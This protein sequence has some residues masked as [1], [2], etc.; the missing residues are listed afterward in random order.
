LKWIVD[1]RDPWTDIYYYNLFYPT[2]I[3][4]II[5]SRYELNVL[6]LADRIIT[7]GESLKD[8]FLSKA[9]GLERKTEVIPNGYDDEDFEGVSGSSPD[10]FTV[11]YIGTLSDAYPLGGL[12]KG[13]ARL[14][15]NGIDFRL[16]FVGFVSEKQKALI[17]SVLKEADVDF[18]RYVDHT[19]AIRYMLGSSML[20]LIIPDHSSSKTIVT[21][22]LFEYLATESL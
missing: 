11:S 17:L 18:I 16:R 13:L 20:L 6:E 10:I 2:I 1:L 4:K 15:E 8:L 21:G 12:M 7:I 22:K 5:D 19:S 3:S 9:R 14:R